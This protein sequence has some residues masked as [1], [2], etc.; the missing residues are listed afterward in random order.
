MT[1]P[2][3]DTTTAEQDTAQ[4]FAVFLVG[5]DKGRLIRDCGTQMQEVVAAI[6]QTG[7]AGV[8][9]LRLDLK[10]AGKSGAITV[11]GAVTTKKPKVDRPE[12]LFF[13]DQ[14]HNLVRDDPSQSTLY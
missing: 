12:S 10:P 11:T 5:I 4:D 7:K 3:D 6:E 9:N 2:D 14:H 1:Q 8:I 13:P